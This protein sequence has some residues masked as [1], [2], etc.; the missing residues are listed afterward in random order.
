[1]V[2]FLITYNILINTIN[3]YFFCFLIYIFVLRKLNQKLSI[4]LWFLQ[5][6]W[7]THNRQT[8]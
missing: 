3:Y 4:V 5:G 6:M 7:N 8:H 1:M 2:A